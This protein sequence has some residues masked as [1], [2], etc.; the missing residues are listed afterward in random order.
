MLEGRVCRK[1]KETMAA[2]LPRE[3]ECGL[4]ER[5]DVKLILEIVGKRDIL[6]RPGGI[7]TSKRSENKEEC[8]L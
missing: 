8:E 4:Q 5:G 7:L 3:E 6:Q 1:G 2:I